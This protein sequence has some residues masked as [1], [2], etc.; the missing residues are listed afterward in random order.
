[1]PPDGD[2]AEERPFPDAL[3]W[4]VEG[5]QGQGDGSSGA[6]GSSQTGERTP[7]VPESQGHVWER[8]ERESGVSVKYS[9]DTLTF[10]QLCC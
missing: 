7:G 3:C 2:Y 8:S 10:D 5:S 9:T 6:R 4:G 1:M